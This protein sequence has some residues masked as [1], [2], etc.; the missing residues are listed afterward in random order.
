[1][2]I[3]RGRLTRAAQAVLSGWVT[4]L[5][6]I[7]GSVAMLVK[8]QH[9]DISYHVVANAEEVH[10]SCPWGQHAPHDWSDPCWHSL[11]VAMAEEIEVPNLGQMEEDNG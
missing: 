2:V 4:P 8:S 1:M 9:A 7:D 6:E 11:A 3:T 10:C 5:E